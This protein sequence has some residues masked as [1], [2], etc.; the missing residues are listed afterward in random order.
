VVLKT[1]VLVS[2]LVFH[3]LGLGHLVFSGHKISISKFRR[4][5]V[6]RGRNKALFTNLCC[7]LIVESLNGDH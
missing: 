2:R 3:S 7:M 1:W 5:F 6:G 4:T